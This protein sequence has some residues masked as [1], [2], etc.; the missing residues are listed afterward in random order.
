MSMN[1]KTG[2]FTQI[3]DRRKRASLMAPNP[4]ELLQL[5]QDVPARLDVTARR[6]LKLEMIADDR[7]SGSHV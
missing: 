6:G 2:L 4:G 7:T 1:A 5:Y 3:S